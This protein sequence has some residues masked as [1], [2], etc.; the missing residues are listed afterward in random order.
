MTY[1]SDD[2][3]EVPWT[4]NDGDT[5]FLGEEVFNE[6]IKKSRNANWN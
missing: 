6:C 2:V 1:F 4:D 3:R 5:F